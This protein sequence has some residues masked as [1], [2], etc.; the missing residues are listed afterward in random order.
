MNRRRFINRSALTAAGLYAAQSASLQAVNAFWPKEFISQRP[1]LSKRTFSSTAV[2]GLIENLKNR[3]ADPELAWMF[4]NCYPNTL[5]T[6]VDY[7]IVDGKPDTFI[8]TGDIDAMWLRDSTAQ[9]WPYLPLIRND[10]KLR[11]LIVGLINRQALCVLKDPYANAFYK[12]LS[13]ESEWK[14][15]SPEPIPGVHERKWEIDSLCYVVRLAYGYFA[16]TNDVSPF[17][18]RWREAMQ[19]LVKTLRT[20]QRKDGTS[21]YFFVRRT[22]NVIDA[23]PFRGTGQPAKPTGMI[24]SMFRPSDDSTV[25]PYLIPS[26]LMAVQAL[27]QLAEIFRRGLHDENFATDCE[28]LARE[29]E[30][31]IITY[32]IV[33]HPDIGKIY[34]YEVDGYGGQILM[35]DANVPSL[36]S[37]AYLGVHRADDPLYA[38]TRRFLI[39]EAN[40]WYLTGNAADG[41]G[42]PHTGK[43]SIWPMG[44]IL[45]ALTSQSDDEIARC[46]KLLKTTHA[47]TGFMHESFDKDDASLFSRKWFA[48]ANTLF[49]ELIIKLSKERPALIF[50]NY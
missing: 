33:E 30:T 48:W 38:N 10:K 20:E 12:D 42:S 6:T 4:E 39:S 31:G 45:R 32:G 1:P 26:N 28:S 25:L 3:I 34:A 22:D 2:D 37:L 7:E 17:D 19:L 44:I 11:M 36:M 15:D 35:D 14:S 23:P 43:R 41:Q 50:K 27:R 49:G 47:G 21:P 29:V 13:K 8:I 5:D 18:Q 46:L 24:C 16:H 9:V 40:P